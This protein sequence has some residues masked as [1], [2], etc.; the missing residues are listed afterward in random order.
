MGLKNSPSINVMSSQDF[1][2]VTRTAQYSD[3]SIM[4]RTRAVLRRDDSTGNC[5]ITLDKLLA[6]KVPGDLAKL[7]R[8][9]ARDRGALNGS[10]IPEQQKVC[11]AGQATASSDKPTAICP[12][13]VRPHT[14]ITHRFEY[15][16]TK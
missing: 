4:V 11:T 9:L 7:S 6:V 8:G 5:S 1:R 16:A 14:T 12:S 15:G 2:S 10:E 3:A 13:R